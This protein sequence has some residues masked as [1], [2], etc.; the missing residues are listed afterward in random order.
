M[1]VPDDNP[2][3]VNLPSTPRPFTSLRAVPSLLDVSTRKTR[4]PGSSSATSVSKAGFS[5]AVSPTALMALNPIDES[6]AQ[7]GHC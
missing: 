7:D 4:Q 6:L 2:E 3:K 1:S 5:A